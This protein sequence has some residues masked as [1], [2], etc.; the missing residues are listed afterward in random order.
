MGRCPSRK[1][2][3][4]LF[5][6]DESLSRNVAKALKLVGYDVVTIYETF[7]GRLGVL[8]P[9]I[10]EWCRD[11]NAVW[12]HA[13][14]QARKEH[15]KQIIATGIAFLWIYRPKGVMSSK[16][17]LRILS[18]VLPDIID[19]FEKHPKQLHYRASVHGELPHTRIRLKPLTL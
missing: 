4:V 7:G 1:V 15:K 8:D 10:I 19:R 18:Y 9:E 16:Q 17:Q 12:V 13:D 6:L 14:D 11:H 5:L 2:A 3:T